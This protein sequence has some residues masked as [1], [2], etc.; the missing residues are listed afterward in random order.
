M[1]TF[2]RIL[3]LREIPDVMP[4]SE[5]ENEESICRAVE[6]NLKMRTRRGGVRNIRSL[7]RE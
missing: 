3:S 2:P 5:I 6:S 7:L 4:L 1:A